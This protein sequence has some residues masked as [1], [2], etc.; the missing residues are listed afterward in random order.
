MTVLLLLNKI[1]RCFLQQLKSCSILC[2]KERFLCSNSKS[3]VV[4]SGTNWTYLC[5]VTAAVM[6]A[7]LFLYSFL[8]CK[9]K[10]MLESPSGLLM[11]TCFRHC[12]FVFRKDM[13]YGFSLMF[14]SDLENYLLHFPQTQ[15]GRHGR[16]RARF[17]YI[18][19]LF[20]RCQRVVTDA[21]FATLWPPAVINSS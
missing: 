5:S 1:L 20:S 14:P 19:C 4:F 6:Q 8:L 11:G 3:W 9:R 12:N 18:V 17:L 13:D 7:R 21:N 15:R 2:S 10:G 16:G